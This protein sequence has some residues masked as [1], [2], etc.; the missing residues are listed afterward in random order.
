MLHPA[1]SILTTIKGFSGGRE[2][3]PTL[4]TGLSEEDFNKH[5]EDLVKNYPNTHTAYRHYPRPSFIFP[6]LNSP[7][8]NPIFYFSIAIQTLQDA[9]FIQEASELQHMMFSP[10]EQHPEIIA[11]YLNI[12]TPLSYTDY[13]EISDFN[14]KRGFSQDIQ[15]I[16]F[17]SEECALEQLPEFRNVTMANVKQLIAD[18]F[19]FNSTN[20]FG[21]NI[22]WYTD[23]PE[24][25]NYISQHT[26]IDLFHIDHTG[27]NLFHKCFLHQDIDCSYGTLLTIIDNMKKQDLELTEEFVN[28][29]EIL[30]VL[31]S[32]FQTQL[33]EHLTKIADKDFDSKNVLINKL[34]FVY[35]LAP[36]LKEFD[37]KEFLKL[38]DFVAQAQQKQK[39]APNRQMNKIKFLTDVH[40]SL[41]EIYMPK[42]TN[43]ATSKLKF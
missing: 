2:N 9:K 24:L 28:D 30:D 32:A 25:T 34:E 11:N 16:T 1:P 26:D 4:K 22:L 21:R 23:T 13:K 31:N 14:K 19:D 27:R 6:M 39:E 10:Y 35:D 18:G 8:G 36:I 3:V 17:Q 41:L 43:V 38:I 29:V 20:I 40:E 37:E 5:M 42:N 12:G 33:T 7:D 15:P